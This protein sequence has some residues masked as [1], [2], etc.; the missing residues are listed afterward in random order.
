MKKITLTFAILTL[1]ACLAGCGNDTAATQ[2]SQAPAT[3]TA[4]TTS[5]SSEPSSSSE[6]PAETAN[7]AP[8][9]DAIKWDEV[10]DP[11]ID[12]TMKTKLKAAVD[13]IVA[14]DVDQ[15]HQAIGKELG[16]AHDYLLD[17]SMQF[18]SVEAAHK[19]KDHVLVPV[20]GQ[21]MVPD[22]AEATEGI[23]TF[24]FEKDKQGEWNIVSI[25]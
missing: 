22:A 20:S 1:T 6:K 24:Y 19:E 23:Y 7:S 8:S 17:N 10:K 18:K 15:F 25:D 3:N 9:T 5:S 13:A 4:P 14:K 11:L 16:T 21:M 12:E 2:S